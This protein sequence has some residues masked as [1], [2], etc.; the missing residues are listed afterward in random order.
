MIDVDPRSSTTDMLADEAQWFSHRLRVNMEAPL[1]SH[2]HLLFD[3]VVGVSAFEDLH[4]HT[5]ACFC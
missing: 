1:C 3:A 5:D 4:F 2:G